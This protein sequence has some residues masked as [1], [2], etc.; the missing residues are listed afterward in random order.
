MESMVK[1]ET[2]KLV[3]LPDLSLLSAPEAGN[4]VPKR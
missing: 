3:G 1:L 4:S 2:R